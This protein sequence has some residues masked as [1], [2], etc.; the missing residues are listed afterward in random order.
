MAMYGIG[1]A[2]GAGDGTDAGRLDHRQLVVALELLYQPADRHARR[3]DGHIFVHDP[4][5]HARSAQE[6]APHR[7]SWASSISRW[8]WA[9]CRSCWTAAS[10]PTGSPRTGYAS[11]PS[12]RSR[13]WYCWCI[14]ELRF[15]EPILDLT[16]L[17]IPL[18]VIAVS[19]IT[20]MYLIL[21]GANLLN[22]L[23]FQELLGYSAWRAGLAV[24][25]RGFGTLA[26][27]AVDRAACAPRRLIPRWLVG[28]GFAG[29]G[30]CV[31]VD[32]PLDAGR[33][34]GQLWLADFSLG[35]RR[36]LDLSR[37]C[38]RRLWHAWSASGWVMRRAC[39]R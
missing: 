32:G 14:R 28:V 23:F 35:S 21:Y 19:I 10:A 24:V 7:L 6:G 37:P 31:V 16:I 9:C 22:P 25:P 17:K 20:C 2:G 5:L 13:C 34:H 36:R 4:E 3:D 30:L 11:S 27:D 38:R 39:T 18:F 33:R 12:R 26:R 29:A 1:I 8:D 15:P